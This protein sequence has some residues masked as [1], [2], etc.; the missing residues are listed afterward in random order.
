MIKEGSPSVHAEEVTSQTPIPI[1]PIANAEHIPEDNVLIAENQYS[2]ASSS[3][4][5]VDMPVPREFAQQ[6]CS[7]HMPQAIPAEAQTVRVIPSSFSRILTSIQAPQQIPVV[8]QPSYAA[9]SADA[10]GPV[11][12]FAHS[13]PIKGIPVVV[14]AICGFCASRLTRKQRSYTPSV[15]SELSVLLQV[16]FS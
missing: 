1:E 14:S 8:V 6:A 5:A 16:R 11:P 12:S 13:V 15:S 4:H 3:P 2:D 10:H 9:M 7:P